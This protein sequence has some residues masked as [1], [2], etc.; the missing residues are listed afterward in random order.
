MKL[1]PNAGGSPRPAPK[2]RKK[3]LDQVAETSQELRSDVLVPLQSSVRL[4]GGLAVARPELQGV[5]H[6]SQVESTLGQQV[7]PGLTRGLG[8]TGGALGGVVGVHRV[9]DG[10]RKQDAPQVISG[11]AE[12]TTSATALAS[13]G[14]IGGA[15]VLGPVGSV[16]LATRGLQALEEV[17]RDKRLAG[18]GDMV[19]AS[20]LAARFLQA[21]LALSLGLGGL[22]TGVAVLRGLSSLEKPDLRS[23]TRGLGELT[24]A[25]G[26]TLVA[27]GLAVGPGVAV[28]LAGAALP[29]L[30]RTG[31][32]K[33]LD[34]AV[35]ELALRTAP[36]A[37][38]VRQSEERIDRALAPVTI[39]VK[40]AVKAVTQPLRPPLEKLSQQCLSLAQQSLAAFSQTRL[41][42]WMEQGLEKVQQGVS[43]I[44]GIQSPPEE[45]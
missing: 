2:E 28:M 21:P 14:V 43:R 32:R 19:T 12:M 42:G 41:A 29:L 11:A 26:L 24:S 44:P 16:L 30:R 1:E 17:D 7:S 25:L 15:A 35:R 5:T 23:Q 37:K 10:V 22:A 36:L 6:R 20:T 33:Y 39:P 31:L 9:L 4:S 45:G 13:A 34:P 8:I 18:A 40:E 3:P 27:T 38:R